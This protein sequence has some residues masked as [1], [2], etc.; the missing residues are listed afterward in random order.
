M[1]YKSKNKITIK[2]IIITL[3]ITIFL[4]SIG[5][6]FC[7]RERLSYANIINCGLSNIS[8]IKPVFDNKTLH[9]PVMRGIE[10]NPQDPLKFKFYFDTMNKGNISEKDINRMIKYFLGFLSLP[11][12]LLWVNLSPYEK[13]RVIDPIL[14]NLDI[15]K[16][17]LLQD[18]LLKQLT[19]V[20]IDPRLPQGKKYW[21]EIHAMTYK[22]A[23]TSKVPIDLSY[24][25]WIVPD[26]T[27]IYKHLDTAASENTQDKTQATGKTKAF[28]KEAKLKVLM[29]DDYLGTDSQNNLKADRCGLSSKNSITSNSKTKLINQEAKK[30]FKKCLLPII[31]WQVNNAKD[32]S[33]LRQLY[34]S[35][36]LAKY[37]KNLIINNQHNLAADWQIL[38]NYMDSQGIRSIRLS[39]AN[40][41]DIIYNAY[42]KN[43]KDGAFNY[44]DKRQGYKYF[45]GGIKVTNN[46]KLEEKEVSSQE[47]KSCI[48]N[49]KIKQVEATFDK[50]NQPGPEIAFRNVDDVIFNLPDVNIPLELVR[51]KLSYFDDLAQ[52]TAKGG[53]HPVIVELDRLPAD[54]QSM[55]GSINLSLH[56][57]KISSREFLHSAVDQIIFTPLIMIKSSQGEYFPA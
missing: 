5:Y 28:V 30:I 18:Y 35:L 41:K 4:G 6:Y 24:K 25:V 44:N 36:I 33:P 2:L 52:V 9:L 57:E 7:G 54:M 46:W 37:F 49:P 19:T 48:L 8:V 47:L 38:S 45:S 34:Y 55:L 1:S 32:F 20:L 12:D 26:K 17:L 31:Q 16:A 56:G 51:Q 14:A 21:Q 40:I 11:Q 43:F 15:G 29:E 22:I 10:F 39:E 27:I 3:S 23:G 53:H 50:A 42:L 13:D